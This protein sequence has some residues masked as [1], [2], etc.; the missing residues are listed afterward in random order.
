MITFYTDIPYGPHPRQVL[1]LWLAATG[2]PAPLYLFFHGGGFLNG[3]KSHLSPVTR[4]ALLAGG[5]SVASANYRFTDDP[6]YLAPLLDG[7]RAVQCL[8]HHAEHW[9]LDP[10]RFAAGGCSAGSCTAFWLGFG[11]DQAR[12]DSPDPVARQSTRL[13]AIGAN[14]IQSTL[15][16]HWIRAN[17]A[18]PTWTLNTIAKLL[19][20]SLDEY[21]TPEARAR[22]REVD[23]L[24]MLGL[25]APPVYT[26]NMTPNL[27][28]TDDLAIGPG[29][30]HPIFALALKER[31]DRLGIECVVRLRE[32][33]PELSDEE[34]HAQ[35][36]RELAAF[37]VRVFATKAVA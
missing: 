28:M 12:P 19:H 24:G 36:D 11:P 4:D 9:N 18:G 7:A 25:G 23:F 37:I 31:M 8:R 30:H 15:D 3:D 26:Y 13:Q 33:L 5:V 35:F 20:I 1:D 10:A 14:E 2:Q 34:A 27:P 21:D 16:A 6:E 32:D 17:I 29:I 22:F